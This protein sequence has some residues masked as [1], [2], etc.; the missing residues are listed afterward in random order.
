[1]LRTIDEAIREHR[2]TEIEYR[3]LWPDGTERRISS[4][5]HFFYDDA[6]VPLRGAGV[7]IDVTER[8]ALEAQLRQSQRMEAIGLLAGGIAHDFNN[9]LTAIGGYTDMVL[10]TLDGTDTRREDLNEV[11]K[12]AQ[13]AAALTRHLLAVSR[14]Q[15]L[16]PTVLDVNGMVVDVQKLLRRTIPENIDLQLE[17][18]PVLGSVRADRGQLEQVL[19]NL[20]INAGDAMPRGGHLRL[21]TETVDVDEALAHRHLPMPAGRYVRLT[22]S[23]TGIGMTEKTQ[24]HIFEPFFTTKERGKGTGFGLATV[25]GIVKQSDGFIWV[26]SHVGRGTKFE[27]YLPVVNEPAEL[28]VQV[29]QAVETGAGSQTILLAEDDGAVRR[30]ARD[31]LANQGYTVLDARDGDE[32]L[33]TA[34]RYPNP[35]HLLIADVVM[36]GLSG[37]D[38][39]ARLS[40]ER[41][42]VR[43]LYTSGYA[44]NVMV[45]AGFE[46]GLR[47]LAKPFLPVDLLRKVRETFGTTD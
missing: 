7:S 17:L 35:I 39:A 24:A 45:R 29:A 13:R 28:P 23:D 31:V 15:I 9:L 33:A 20:A 3:T 11:A 32:A 42:D 46:D 40:L 4:T 10:G 44:E 47:L 36:P 22:V 2:D 12:A 5:A 43:V 37:R 8:R 38:L 6:G 27:V 34:R 25:Y 26:E 19:L 41:P 16:Q 30:L 18:S 14:R 21:A 1:V